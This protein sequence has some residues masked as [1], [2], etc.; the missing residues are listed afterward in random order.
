[1]MHQEENLLKNTGGNQFVRTG[2]RQC[3]EGKDI[4]SIPF[5]IFN[6]INFAYYYTLFIFNVNNQTR[7]L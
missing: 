5:R 1:M 6:L 4:F 3:K 7:V 2:S